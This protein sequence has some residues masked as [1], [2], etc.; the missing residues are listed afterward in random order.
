MGKTI[1]ISSHILSELQTLCNRVAII[2][3]GKLIYNGPVQGVTQQLSETRVMWAKVPLDQ[4]ARATELL[5]ARPE[6]RAVDCSLRPA[7]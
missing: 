7:F 5:Q 6:V 3:R 2:E 1:I 4:Q